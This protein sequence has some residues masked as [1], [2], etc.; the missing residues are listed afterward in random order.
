[1]VSD[2]FG[3]QGQGTMCHWGH[4]STDL[5]TLPLLGGRVEG[6]GCKISWVG[7]TMEV[8]NGVMQS[9]IQIL[10]HGLG[11][12]LWCSQVPQTENCPLKALVAGHG[13]VALVLT[14]GTDFV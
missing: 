12:L 6:R 11:R 14:Y 7:K 9:V 2:L 1:M 4:F 5:A 3:N 10:I 8:A 13:T